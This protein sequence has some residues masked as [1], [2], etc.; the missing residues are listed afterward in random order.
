MDNFDLIVIGGGPGGYVCAIRAA[1]LGLKTACVES[2][3]T[4]GGTCLN[5]G[6]IPSKSLLN[7]SENFH[8]AKKDFNRQGIE[9]E[10]IKLN[11]E[12]MMSN[13]NKSVQVLT[14]GVEFLFKKNKVTY[15]KG[16]TKDILKIKKISN[17]KLELIFH[18]AEFSRIV[19]SFKYF[20]DCWESNMQGTKKVI[21]LAL[22]KKAKFVYSASSSKFGPKKNQF[23]SPYAWT[24]AKN[25]ELI[26]C[27]KEW[28][29]LNYVIAYFYNV[30]G[31]NQIKNHHMSAV[32]GIFE[33]QYLK[34]IPLTV[35]SPGNQKRDFT[36]VYDI[37]DGFIKA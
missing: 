1:Q 12:K 31:P 4:L 37:V 24:K 22:I 33:N 10:G 9:I 15:I 35:V 34:G 13:K 5:V 28:Y 25:V 36:H 16:N 2:R 29:G 21:E 14:K 11:I 27:Y 6:C 7:L 3:G 8:K 26:K 23:L 18:L 20:E 17:S 32:I 30:F 19:Q